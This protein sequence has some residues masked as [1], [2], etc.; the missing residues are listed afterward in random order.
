M[1]IRVCNII[2]EI[3]SMSYNCRIE[4]GVG[5]SFGRDSTYLF[6]FLSKYNSLINQVL[7]VRVRFRYVFI[8][9]KRDVVKAKIFVP[10]IEC[11][12]V[13]ES[14]CKDNIRIYL[15]RYLHDKMIRFLFTAH[16]LIDRIDTFI[17]RAK[18]SSGVRGLCC[19]PEIR[20]TNCGIIHARP[21]VKF[22]IEKLDYQ[23]I[24]FFEPE[25][26]STT[27]SIITSSMADFDSCIITS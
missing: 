5:I 24:I 11:L 8:G 23:R 21:M 3:L 26:N 1:I 10:G 15:F 22:M 14:K 9:K 19:L 2:E 4:V 7:N 25:D 12:S 13:T 18:K 16:T 6:I 27:R 17:M 20:I